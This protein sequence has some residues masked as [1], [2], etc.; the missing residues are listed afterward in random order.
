MN[1]LI[2]YVVKKSLFGFILLT[3]LM[4]S[5]T[6]HAGPTWSG[7]AKIVRFQTLEGVSWVQLEPSLVVNPADCSSYGG[8]HLFVDESL[9]AN[10]KNYKEFLAMLMTAW[11]L[12]QE[13]NIYATSCIQNFPN[14][15]GIELKK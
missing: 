15:R 8:W 3:S 1:K 14:A 11:T 9:D 6:A 2:V 5:N 7:F 10:R 12:N 4:M 13:V